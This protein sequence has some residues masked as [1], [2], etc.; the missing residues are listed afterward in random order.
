MNSP[1]IATRTTMSRREYCPKRRIRRADHSMGETRLGKISASCGAGHTKRW[2]TES[3]TSRSAPD[4]RG[5]WLGLFGFRLF[6]FCV[7][8]VARV[9]PGPEAR[10][11]LSVHIVRPI[12]I[13]VLLVEATLD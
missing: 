7:P 1:A 10:L 8:G 5:S 6:D 13:V 2:P 11:R 12:D 3:A 4:Q 9:L